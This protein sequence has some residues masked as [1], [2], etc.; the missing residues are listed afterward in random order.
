ML[1]MLQL[2]VSLTGVVE[3]MNATINWLVVKDMEN[4]QA[5]QDNRHAI[6]NLTTIL[7]QFQATRN[8]SAAVQDNRH[9]GDFE[10]Q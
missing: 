6:S 8:L 2:A 5:I 10:D 3:A 4:R 9:R 7:R 1:R